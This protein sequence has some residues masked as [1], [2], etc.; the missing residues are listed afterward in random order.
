ML[1]NRFSFFMLML[2]L[3]YSLSAQEWSSRIALMQEHLITD[4]AKFT[5][6]ELQIDLAQNGGDLF[7]VHVG[8]F[9]GGFNLLFEEVLETDFLVKDMFVY[10]FGMSY[11]LGNFNLSFQFENFLNASQR[12]ADILPSA[13]Q[14]YGVVQTI[15]Y[16]QD[17]PFMAAFGISFT[18]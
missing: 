5:S 7:V 17:T 11:E 13:E 18:F 2:L 12:E 15:T 1:S 8:G 6:D 10:N 16:E 3:G 4:T 14:L 9:T